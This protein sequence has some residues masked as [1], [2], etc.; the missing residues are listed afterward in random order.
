MIGALR[1]TLAANPTSDY[2]ARPHLR[3]VVDAKSRHRLGRSITASFSFG[4]PF[5]ELGLPGLKI[6][7]GQERLSSGWAK[8]SMR[9]TQQR[10]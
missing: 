5:I 6:P 1:V 3:P 8:W 2:E 10:P 9:I 7:W 4:F